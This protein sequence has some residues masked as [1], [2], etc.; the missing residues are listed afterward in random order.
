MLDVVAELGHLR[1]LAEQD[2]N[3]RFNRLYRLVRQSGLLALARERIAGNKGAQTPGVD[4]E[5]M[6]TFRQSSL[7]T[8]L[9]F[10]IANKTWLRRATRCSVRPS[11]AKR[12]SSLWSARETLIVLGLRRL[13]GLSAFI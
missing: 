1:K 11:C 9:E 6:P 7:M 5:S 2:A 3:K 10:F 12:S 8:V 13:M 4:G